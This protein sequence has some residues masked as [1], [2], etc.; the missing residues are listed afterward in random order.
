MA[1]CSVL[2]TC[3]NAAPYLAE[4]IA[5][6]LQQTFTD[7]QFII[8]DDGSTDDSLKIMQAYAAKD[9]RIKVVAASHEGRIAS[10]QKGL[11]LV[12]TVWCAIL[13]EDDVAA[14]TRQGYV[15]S[16]LMGGSLDW[17]RSRSLRHKCSIWNS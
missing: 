15:A 17:H 10:L 4:S 11:E 14:P 2:T 9:A 12:Q 8:V 13:D 16:E 1:I 5:S 7:Y 6:V 3:F